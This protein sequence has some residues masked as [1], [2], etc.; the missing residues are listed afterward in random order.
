MPVT[1]KNPKKSF[2]LPWIEKPLLTSSFCDLSGF[3]SLKMN[4]K[5]LNRDGPLD[6]LIIHTIISFSVARFLD[7]ASVGK[8]LVVCVV[9]K[10]L[11]TFVTWT[12]FFKGFDIC[13]F[14]VE[15]WIRGNNLLECWIRVRLVKR[16]N[17]KDMAW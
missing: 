14:I 2:F 15:F 7:I 9:F 3:Q 10:L 12:S 4:A 6:R 1:F 8:T 11:Y 17:L 13:F 5:S 16:F